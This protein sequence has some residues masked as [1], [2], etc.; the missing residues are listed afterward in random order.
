MALELMDILSISIL[1][2]SIAGLLFVYF[3]YSRVLAW[4][5]LRHVDGP[6]IASFSYLYMSWVTFSGKQAANYRKLN[7]KYGSLVRIGPNDLITDDPD[8]IR[9]MNGARSKYRR[10]SWYNAMRM[11]PYL[12]SLFSTMDTDEHD[13]LKAQLSFGYGGKEN[14][15]IEADI[16]E[17]LASLMALIRRKYLSDDRQLRPMDFAHRI[18]F[19]TL[20]ALTKIAYGRAFGYLTTDTDVYGYIESAEV[21]VPVLVALADVPWLERVFFSE[22]VLNLIGPKPTDEKGTGKMIA[23]ARE[24]ASERFGPDAKDRK[25]MLGS[26]VRHGVS[27]RRCESEILFQIIA[28]SDTTATAI[29]GTMLSMLASPLVYFR[30]REEIDTAIAEG[31]ISSPIKL[32]EA[33]N[34]EYLQA[35]IYEGLR[36]NIPFSG[37]TM[38]QVPPEGDTINGKFIP[39]GTRIAHSFLSV[40]RST[41]IYGPDAELF[42]PERWLN[43]DPDKHREMTNTTELVFGYGRFGC[44]GKNVAFMEMNKAYVELLRNFDFQLVDPHNPMETSNRNMFFQKHMWVKITERAQRV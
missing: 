37:L 40:Q 34:L 20:D 38:K 23:V 32:D 22:P 4:Y 29:R 6:W 42:R 31:R 12:P 33:K 21:Q 14:P 24:V 10:S 1:V 44:S 7:Q 25:D 5:R 13:K 35:V 28:G 18:N 17:Q 2:P 15:T 3:V 8:L 39:G 11:D 30:L 36:M 19:F 43:I 26:F 9:R 16:D 27:Q 41:A